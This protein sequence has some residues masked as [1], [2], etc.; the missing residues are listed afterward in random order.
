MGRRPIVPRKC[1]FATTSAYKTKPTCQ[2]IRKCPKMEGVFRCN[3]C[4]RTRR[5]AKGE[6]REETQEKRDTRETQEKRDT[7]ERQREETQEKRHKRHAHTHTCMH[8]QAHTLA[9]MYTHPHTHPRTQT[10][11]P[12]LS[13]NFP[14]AICCHQGL[15]ER[16]DAT[17][18]RLLLPPPPATSLRSPSCRLAQLRKLPSNPWKPAIMYTR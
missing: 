13:L 12:H 8:T 10:L 9:H 17:N 1:T 18:S 5:R 6:T 2:R 15:L 4:C 7:R 11:T 3:L 14:A 16:N